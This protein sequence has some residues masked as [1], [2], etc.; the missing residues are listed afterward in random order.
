[1]RQMA[2]MHG[3]MPRP[4]TTISASK[5]RNTP[6]LINSRTKFCDS[7]NMDRRSFCY[8]SLSASAASSG[9]GL[10]TILTSSLREY[11]M[12]CKACEHFGTRDEGVYSPGHF[13]CSRQQVILPS[14]MVTVEG[15]GTKRGLAC[16]LAKEQVPISC[17][18]PYLR[19]L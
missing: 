12:V 14:C 16:M 7:S 1:M 11:S 5:S 8:R 4:L 9:V 13:V 15:R 6:V 17:S 18:I 3:N 10:A 19:R 2:G